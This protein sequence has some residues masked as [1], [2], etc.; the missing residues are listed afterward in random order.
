[1]LL[2]LKALQGPPLPLPWLT[3]TWFCLVDLKK[4]LAERAA[5]VDADMGMDVSNVL[6]TEQ[7]T[8]GGGAQQ[9]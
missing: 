4:L 8:A 3:L 7:V 9:H 1:M 6:Q 5:A 2:S